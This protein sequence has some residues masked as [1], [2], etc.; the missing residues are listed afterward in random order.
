MTQASIIIGIV[1]V[2]LGAISAA[3]GAI[4]C[5]TTKVSRKKEKKRSDGKSI[6]GMKCGLR[7]YIIYIY[8]YT[9]YY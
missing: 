7:K 3:Y 8:I 6:A 5:Y 4:L 9:T 2:A 1:L